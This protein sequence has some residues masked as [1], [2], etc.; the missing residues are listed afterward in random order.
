METTDLAELGVPTWAIPD[1]SKA[2]PKRRLEGLI[3]P[4]VYDLQP[5]LSAH[6]LWKKVI[7]S[8]TAVLESIGMPQVAE[9]TG[10]RPYEVLV[11]AS[12]IEREA[13]KSDFAK[14]SRVTYNRLAKGMELKYDSTVNYVLD[15][16]EIRTTP[17]DRAKAGPYNTYLNSGLPPAPISAPS[18]EAI[19]AA[20]K[21]SD[22]PWLYFVRCEKDGTSCFAE[23]GEQHEQNV[24][25]AQ[26]RGAY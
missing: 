8:S 3:M 7:S 5:G 23:T 1:A 2:E 22:G 24:R 16:P 10:F 14:V 19:D 25:D 9:N 17:A 18:K 11:M 20:I 12:L 26:A 6:D 15:R 13:I 21:P 4:G